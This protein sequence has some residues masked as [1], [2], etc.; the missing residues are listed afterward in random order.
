MLCFEKKI[1][2]WLDRQT[3]Q[4]LICYTHCSLYIVLPFIHV[5]SSPGYKQLRCCFSG[6]GVTGEDWSSLNL[7]QCKNNKKW[8]VFMRHTWCFGKLR[9]MHSAETPREGLIIL[10]KYKYSSEIQLWLLHPLPACVT[11]ISVKSFIWLSF[12]YP[13]RRSENRLISTS[14]IL[15]ANIQR[16]GLKSLFF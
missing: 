8:K 5:N 6:T 9:P 11:L 10:R 7:T 12:C 16:P 3:D 2:Q 1:Q 15:M 4:A 13:Q 14:R